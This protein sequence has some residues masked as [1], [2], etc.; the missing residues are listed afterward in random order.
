MFPNL[1]RADST[2]VFA[3]RISV[4]LQTSPPSIT[5]NWLPDDYGSS[6]YTIYRKG[7]GDT[8]WGAPIATL[9]GSALS[10]TDTG[11]V[12]GSTYEYQVV[13]QM[14]I[15]SLAYGYVLTGVNP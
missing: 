11:V 8:S 15:G 3:V 4:V 13:E 1:A 6:G 14:A 12:I 2:W 5:L 7:K 10:F 9:G